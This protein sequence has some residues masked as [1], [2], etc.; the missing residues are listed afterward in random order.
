MA[1]L[2]DFTMGCEVLLVLNY[3]T[4]HKA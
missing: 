2:R 3:K 4:L 1:D